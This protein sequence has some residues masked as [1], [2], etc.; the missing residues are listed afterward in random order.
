MKSKN[1][2]PFLPRL[3]LSHAIGDQL[4]LDFFIKLRSEMYTELMMYSLDMRDILK[5]EMESYA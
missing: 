3:M 2:A 4:Q 1:M 5:Q